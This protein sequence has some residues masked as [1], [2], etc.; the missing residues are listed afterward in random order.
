MTTMMTSGAAFN[1]EERTFLVLRAT[2]ILMI[3]NVQEMSTL[4]QRRRQQLV[5]IGMARQR[6]WCGLTAATADERLGYYTEFPPLWRLEHCR[7]LHAPDQ[8]SPQLQVK[9]G[10][11]QAVIKPSLLATETKTPLAI[12][13]V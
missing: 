8:T 10:H 4:F 1:N 11:P 7:P 13:P 3:V 9:A 12:Y 5:T 2:S 6:R